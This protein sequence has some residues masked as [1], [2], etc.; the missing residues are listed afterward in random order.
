MSAM[1]LRG[2][3]RMDKRWPFDVVRLSMPVLPAKYAFLR[4]INRKRARNAVLICIAV[5]AL[6]LAT[7]I[8][9]FTEALRRR[10]TSTGKGA[11]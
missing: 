11:V 8:A 7:I 10:A 4:E 1:K 9:L 6:F 5:T 2:A 3:S